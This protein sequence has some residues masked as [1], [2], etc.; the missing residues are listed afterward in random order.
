MFSH[1]IDRPIIIFMQSFSLIPYLCG[2]GASTLGCQ[3]G[4]VELARSG[5]LD[6]LEHVSWDDDPREIFRDHVHGPQTQNDLPPADTVEGTT[7]RKDIVLHHAAYLRD[8]V[9]TLARKAE[10]L[11]VVIGGDHSNAAGSIAGLARAKDSFGKT[12]VIWFDAHPD[13][14]TEKTSLS[15]SWHGMPI[16]ALTGIGNPELASLSGHDVAVFDPAHIFYIGLRDIEEGERRYIEDLGI[17]SLSADQVREIGVDKAF[18]KALDHISNGTI[19]R[20]L[21]FDLDGLDARDAPAVGTP[22][23]GGLSLDEIKPVIHQLLRDEALDLLEI[24]E[25]NPILK[26]A[27]QTAQ[28]IADLLDVAQN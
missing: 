1:E 13:I 10:M 11:P 28:V 20:V 15:G 19:A 4:P 3:Y 5:V 12:G 2:A 14:N 9:E 18:R 6:G 7:R 27:D 23:P 22:V 8:K 17:A 16:A 24:V 25:F 26:G 21:S